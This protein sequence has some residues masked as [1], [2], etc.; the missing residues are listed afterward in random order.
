MKSNK[1]KTIKELSPKEFNIIKQGRG[2]GY[3]S[4]PCKVNGKETFMVHHFF[5]NEEMKAVEELIKDIVFAQQRDDDFL[6]GSKELRTKYNS[7]RSR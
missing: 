6:L 7:H 2:E 1:K 5:Q 3:I 4:V